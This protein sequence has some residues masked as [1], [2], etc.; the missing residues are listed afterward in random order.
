VILP[1]EAHGYAARESVLHMLAEE[2]DWLRT[3]V[4]AA[5]ARAEGAP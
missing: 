5:G 1:G 3:H 4:E 2:I